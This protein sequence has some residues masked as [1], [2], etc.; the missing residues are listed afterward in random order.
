MVLKFSV[1][2]TMH[3]MQKLEESAQ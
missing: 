2:T 1:T 3:T